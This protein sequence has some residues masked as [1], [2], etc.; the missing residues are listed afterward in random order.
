MA[1]HAE[2]PRATERDL[3]SATPQWKADLEEYGV[4][5][6]SGVL[7]QDR[8]DYY[9]DSFFSWLE[10]FPFGFSRG[11]PAT[12]IPQ[13]LPT[14][15][16]GGMY[17]GYAC[18]HEKFV[19]E[20]RLEPSVIKVFEEVW[21]TDQL[22]VSFD[23]FNFTLP[24]VRNLVPKE[25]TAPWPHVDQSPLRKG[26]HCVQGF[27]NIAPNGPKDGGLVVLKGSHK[28]F[29]EF[30]K[31]NDGKKADWGSEDWRGFSEEQVRWFTDRGCEIVKV[32]AGPGDIILWDSRCVHYN[33][34]PEGD[35]LRALFYACYTPARFATTENIEMKKEIFKRKQGTTHWPHDNLW[36]RD[37]WNRPRLGQPDT[38]NRRVPREELEPTD[39]MLKLAGLM[40]Y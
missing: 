28:Y 23:G 36:F 3:E 26:L 37:D 34:L 25:E 22:L 14:N 17:H 30:F 16:K 39:R 18:Q 15:M 7:K 27:I 13:H 32:C 2:S 8:C 40:E 1:P 21:N 5:V 35:Q 11:D 12:H 33:V 6:V 29:A 31:H 38:Y 4:A 19:W 20:A 10:S 24:G 9:I